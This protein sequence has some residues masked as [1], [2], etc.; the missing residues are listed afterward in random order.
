MRRTPKKLDEDPMVFETVPGTGGA[1]L[2]AQP[3][4]GTARERPAGPGA[5]F[6][7][8]EGH[9]LTATDEEAVDPEVRARARAIAARLSLPKPKRASTARRATGRLA[10]L[11]Y[12]DRSDEIDLDRTL[13]SLAEHPVPE[14]EDIYVFERVHA[15]RSV[16]LA[17]D[18]SGSMKGE[19][20][21]TAAATVGALAAELAQDALAVIAFWSD[22]AILLG[23]GEP[24]RPA[25]L[26]DAMLR[27]PARGL[28]NVG[29]P[30]QLAARQL[31]GVPEPDARV[32][33]LSDCVHNAGPDPRPAAARLPRL[34][35]LLD[36][37]GEKDVELGTEMARL[38]RGTF[39]AV[40]THHDVGAALGDIFRA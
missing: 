29:F 6:T 8:E 38:G 1:V 14:D 7:D 36:T 11:P 30:L 33:L 9:L 17:V 4:G 25:E 20:V 26:L 5:G 34:D 22:A 39:H 31:A 19:R 23:L 2:R 18:L 24:V 40:R 16:V 28:T 10:S 35:V 12:R 15:R 32:L 21:R 3:R 37:S 27:L 13:E